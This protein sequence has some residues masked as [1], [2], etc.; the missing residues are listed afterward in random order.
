M[1]D[2]RK[3][4][5]V[6]PACLLMLVCLGTNQAWSV[7][8]DF[9]KKEPYNLTHPQTQTVFFVN[10]LAFCLWMIVGGRVQDRLGPRPVALAGVGLLGLA[11]FLANRL[12]ADYL[13]LSMGLL[14]GMGVSTAYTCPIATAIK[15]FPNHR[16]LMSGLTA[17]GY[18]IGPIVVKL[19]ASGLL[20][21]Q[22]LALDVI[23]LIGLIYVP[24]LL[25][26]GSLLSNPPGQ[27]PHARSKVAFDTSGMFRD[28]R[29]V[30]LFLGMLCGTFP[31][32]L[33]MGSLDSIARAWFG[34]PQTPEDWRPAVIVL[35]AIPAAAG[36]NTLG[37]IFWGYMLDRVGSRRAMLAFQVVLVVSAGGLVLSGVSG[38]MFLLAA[39]L[40][41]FCYGSN[42][43][44]YP[45]TLAR[46]YGPATLGSSYPWVMLAQGISATAPL[47]GGLLQQSTGGYHAGLSVGAAV[48][49]AGLV[50]SLWLG[51]G[52]QFTSQP[53]T[54][55]VTCSQKETTP[56]A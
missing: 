1:S 27:E 15:W 33:M 29:F 30:L 39:M 6:L 32:L 8:V 44:I 25:V 35:L 5:I 55:V 13:W 36:G 10:M 3:R 53:A 26:C 19:I 7:Y 16:G 21:R 56:E 46:M 54:R 41:G 49:V 40:T 14:A 4:Y 28:R 38:A 45:A 23:G 24:V 51:R 52:Q 31:Y 9:L 22:W 43:A 48:G 47:V 18:G 50:L 12:P 34:S 2:N 17:A 37:R 42:F 11:Y 20:Q